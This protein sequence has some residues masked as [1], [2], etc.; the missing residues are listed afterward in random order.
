MKIKVND[1]IAI[2]YAGELVIRRVIAITSQGEPLVRVPLTTSEH[3]IPDQFWLVGSYRR[4]F[5]SLWLKRS[6]HPLAPLAPLVLPRG[7]FPPNGRF[8]KPSPP[9]PL[10]QKSE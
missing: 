9:L 2:P 5:W 7:G 1:A 10:T 4:R 6:F 3:R 8:A